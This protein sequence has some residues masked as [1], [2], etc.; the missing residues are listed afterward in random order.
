M[1]QALHRV[2]RSSGHKKKGQRIAAPSHIPH[3]MFLDL[4]QALDQVWLGVVR[5]VV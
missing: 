2:E 3:G 5:P 4:V 1:L